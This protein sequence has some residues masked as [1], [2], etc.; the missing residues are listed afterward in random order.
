MTRSTGTCDPLTQ[1]EAIEKDLP[2]VIL[3]ENKDLQEQ[4]DFF[5]NICFKHLGGCSSVEVV[6]PMFYRLTAWKPFTTELINPL[7][8]LSRFDICTFESILNKQLA[9]SKQNEDYSF[10]R[11][12]LKIQNDPKNKKRYNVII[13]KR[14]RNFFKIDECNL[15]FCFTSLLDGGNNLKVNDIQIVNRKSEGGASPSSCFSLP[16]LPGTI[17]EN[18]IKAMFLPSYIHTIYLKKNFKIYYIF[19]NCV[20]EYNAGTYDLES[21]YGLGGIF[22]LMKDIFRPKKEKEFIKVLEKI[23]DKVANRIVNYFQLSLVQKHAT[24]AAISQVMARNMSHNIGS[25]VISKYKDKDKIPN[26]IGNGQYI[27]LG[28]Y[29]DKDNGKEIYP[30]FIANFNEYLKDRMDF[31]ADIASTDPVMESSLN[32]VCDIL[33]RFDQNPILLNRISGVESDVKFSLKVRRY[34][35][36]SWQNIISKHKGFNGHVSQYDFPVSIP[37]DI[38]GAQAWYIFIENIIRNIYKHANPKKEFTICIDF[39]DA[40]SDNSVYEISVYDTLCKSEVEVKNKVKSRNIEIDKKVLSENKL[41]DGGLGTIEMKVCAAFIRKLRILSIEDDTFQINKENGSSII[42]DQGEITNELKPSNTILCAYK[43]KL[44]KAEWPKNC[45]KNGKECTSSD[46]YTLGYKF[47]VSKPKEVL[48]VTSNPS[49]FKITENEKEINLLDNGIFVKTPNEIKDDVFPHQFLYILDDGIDIEVKKPHL[50]KR[51]VNSDKKDEII[52]GKGKQGFISSLWKAYFRDSLK[53]HFNSG[54]KSIIIHIKDTKYEINSEPITLEQ[55]SESIGSVETAYGIYLFDHTS[56]YNDRK[57]EKAEYIYHD[58]SWSASLMYKYISQKLDEITAFGYL[59]SVKQKIVVIDERIQQN[60]VKENQ[61][62][63]NVSLYEFYKDLKVIIPYQGN[64]N[65]SNNEVDLNADILAEAKLKEF[66]GKHPDADYFVMHLGL[67]ERL[68]DGEKTKPE[69]SD[70][71]NSLFN[72]HRHKLILTSG[73]GSPP[74]VPD[75][76]CYLPIS[77]LQYA[78]ETVRDKF[79]LTRALFNSR[80]IQ[81]YGNK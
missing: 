19:S 56:G 3:N 10:T 16:A 74:T 32:F 49:D 28:R 27:P 57:I 78:I 18:E 43:H 17:T 63:V 66:I 38:L 75:D 71:I 47:F 80:K 21:T 31:L 33:R 61:K 52:T 6:F 4:L 14:K 51:I 20:S 59:E 40:E 5:L 1:F 42:S 55:P 64:E 9:I 45:K 62:I 76:I 2:F 25:H 8:Y 30:L 15:K 29:P 13:S 70:K 39:K 69:V 12:L 23:T 34:I 81:D 36:G 41:R 22:V 53:N 7:S 24:R 54:N 58:I 68:V 72:S 37:N 26:F 11:Q 60:I 46:C 35:D 48:V 79:Y 44:V 73:R 65:E 77:V 67:I 50:P